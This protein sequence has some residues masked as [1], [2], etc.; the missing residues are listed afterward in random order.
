MLGR[1]NGEDHQ[2]PI[3]WTHSF[4]PSGYSFASETARRLTFFYYIYIYILLSGLGLGAEDAAHSSAT[5]KNTAGQQLGG[6]LGSSLL[7]VQ[8][9]ANKMKL[10]ENG[11][12]AG[13]QARV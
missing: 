10:R 2:P 5:E 13:Q 9:L 8:A 1:Q 4:Q 7:R 6:L 11:E 3:D 12:E